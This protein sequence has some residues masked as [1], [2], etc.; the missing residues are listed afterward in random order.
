[1]I[2]KLPGKNKWR[3]YSSKKVYIKGKGWVHKNMGTYPSKHL[4]HKR[5]GAIEW[6]KKQGK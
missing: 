5:E 2:K 1:M 6:F 4:A 3:V